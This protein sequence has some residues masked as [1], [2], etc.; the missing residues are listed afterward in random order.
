RRGVQ[1]IQHE[2]FTSRTPVPALNRTRRLHAKPTHRTIHPRPLPTQSVHSQE[3]HPLPATAPPLPC[4]RQA[5][6]SGGPCIFLSISVELDRLSI[7]RRHHAAIHASDL[8]RRE[9]VG[10]YAGR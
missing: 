6:Q 2:Q 7:E 9:N 5:F 8:R 1:R 4:G 3:Y 10:P